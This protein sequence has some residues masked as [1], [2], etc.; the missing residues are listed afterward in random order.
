MDIFRSFHDR[1]VLREGPSGIHTLNMKL[2][3]YYRNRLDHYG[4]D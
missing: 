4:L 1:E 2:L 3:Y